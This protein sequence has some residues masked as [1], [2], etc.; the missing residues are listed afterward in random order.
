MHFFWDP[1]VWMYRLVLCRIRAPWEPRGQ[2]QGPEL[3]ATLL[4]ERNPFTA[5]C[6]GWRQPPA[7]RAGSSS[8]WQCLSCTQIPGRSLRYDSGGER[9]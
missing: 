8:W 1:S 6:R 4:A 7:T 5:G 3:W 2:V 9:S